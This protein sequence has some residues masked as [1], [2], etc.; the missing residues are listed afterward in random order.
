MYA[1]RLGYPMVVKPHNLSRGQGVGVCR[2]REQL[3]KALEEIQKLSH[4]AMVEE[5]IVGKEGRLF[6]IGDEIQFMYYKESD[7]DTQVGNLAAGGTLVEFEDKKIPEKLSTS[8][9]SSF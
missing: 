7:A 4:V 6:C 2:S 9:K 3:T 1:E 8:C 5:V